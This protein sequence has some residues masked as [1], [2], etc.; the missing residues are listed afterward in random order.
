MC[1][2]TFAGTPTSTMSAGILSV[3][4]FLLDDAQ[5]LD[6]GWEAD[7]G[8]ALDDGGGQGFGRV[9]G[10]DVAVIVGVELA[11][12]FQGGQDAV[13]EQLAGPQVECAAAVDIAEEIVRKEPLHV[14]AHIA[15][16]AFHHR[17]DA[18]RI[19]LVLNGFARLVAR[20]LRHRAL[21][22]QRQGDTPLRKYF[23]D[24][25][26]GI[27]HPRK[28]DERGGEIHHLAQLLGGNTHIECRSGMGLQ[29]REG[30]SR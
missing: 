12:G 18:A 11:L 1:L 21:L 26:H 28:A 23:I 7:V 5:G 14:L 20:F 13:A 3:V 19:V 16:H 22:F 29:L 6:G 17:G 25:R 2:T 4:I 9:A 30:R 27:Q 15:G 24:R 10:G 8:Q